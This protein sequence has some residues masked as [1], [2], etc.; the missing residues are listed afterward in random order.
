[1]NGAIASA[2][3]AS[4]YNPSAEELRLSMLDLSEGLQ[5]QL[6]ELHARPTP[7]AAER[8]AVNLSGANRLV[9][10]FREALTREGCGD[11]Q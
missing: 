11:G 5:A 6:A 7:D 2:A 10:R 4:L 8:L 9:L 1:M 3:Y